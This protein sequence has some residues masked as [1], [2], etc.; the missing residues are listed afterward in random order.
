MSIEAMKQ[1]LEALEVAN[2][3]V[4]GYYIPKGKTQLPEVESAITALRQAIEQA[5]KQTDWERIAKVQNAKLMA[6]CDEKGGF[7]KL[8]EVMD[9]YEAQKQEPVAWIYEDELPEGYPY[10]AMFEKSRVFDGV[11]MF[12]VNVTPPSQPEPVIDKSAAIRIATVLGWTPPRQPLLDEQIKQIWLN[13]KDHGDDW[14]DVQAIARAIEAAHG[15]KG[16]A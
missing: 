2:S 8:C 16:G 7:E 6:M 5:H 14:L 9:R 10:D 12:P 15:I 3:C 4:D 11:R 13:G 1:A